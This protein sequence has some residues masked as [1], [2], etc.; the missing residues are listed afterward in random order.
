MIYLYV[1]THNVTGL[2]YLGK[3]TKKDPHKYLGSGIHWRNH[4]LKHGKD[5]STEI[6]KECQSKEELKEWGIYYSNLWNIV[7]SSDWANLKLED[8]DGGS[9]PGVLSIRL[10]KTHSKEAKEK[11]S[12]A[13][14]GRVFTEETKQKMSLNHVGHTGK[15]LSELAKEKI[16]K[17]HTGKIVSEHTRALVSQKLKGRPKSPEHLAK[18]RESYKLRS[19]N[20]VQID[21]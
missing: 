9:L 21:T 11:I 1:K 3:T 12:K 18:L 19:K 20:K 17:A 10:G 5:Y 15:Q 13:H 2:K 4:L 6:L 8:G 16:S 7:E 14:T